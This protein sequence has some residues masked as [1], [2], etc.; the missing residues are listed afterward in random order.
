MEKLTIEQ[1]A[2]A[3]DN[4][5][6]VIK[7]NLDA[8]NEITETGANIVNIQSIIN[9][10][11]RAFPELA[12][13]EDERIKENIKKVLANTD[14]KKLG[15]EYSFYDMIAWLEKQGKQTN[16]PQFT[17]DD[18]LALQCCMET[19]KKVQED[20]EL[21]ERL[22]SIH[23]RL[24]DTY[25]LEKQGKQKSSDKA[26]P[27]F[28]EGDWIVFNGLTLY[29]KE[30]VKGFYR[31][32]SKGGIPNSY[33]WDIDNIARL[34]NIE[35]A[36]DGDVLQLGEV[37]AIFKKYIGD[38]NCKCYCSVYDG[39]FEIPNTDDNSYGCYNAV[40]ATKEQRYL[41]EKAMTYAGYT[42]DFEK[43]ET[44][45]LISNGGDFEP[46]LSHKEVTKK[47]EQDPDNLIEESYQ[48]QAEDLL[49]VVTQKSAWTIADEK[50][51]QGVIDEIQAN[52]SNAP[53][54]DLKTYD[55]FLSWLNELKE[56]ICKKL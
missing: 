56:R 10:F 2:R 47:S 23:G 52:K 53:E 16:L 5:I 42:F 6:K 4:A 1:K 12:K 32:I 17:F 9:C 46:E 50:N 38:G 35:D 36:K 48:Q 33:D 22:Q 41:L 13:S 25:W 34:W 21:Y 18:V 45:L 11:H 7:D 24:Y 15:I 37:T 51:L 28:R 55:K 39:E 30:V 20:K 19:V 27:K 43:K 44:R 26:E 29:V 3:Y 8:L 31:T 40:P 49:N 14:F 54:Y